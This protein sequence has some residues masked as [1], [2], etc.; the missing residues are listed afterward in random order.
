MAMLFF[1]A[2]FGIA[3]S[4]TAQPG[5][6]PEKFWVGVGGGVQPVSNSFSDDF[7]KPLYTEDEQVS[8][9]YPVKSGVLVAGS[10]G[11][12][13]WKQLALGVGFTYYTASGDADVDAELPHPF[14]D[15]QFRHVS[16]TTDASRSE[17]GVHIMAAWMLPLS[18]RFRIILS[19][20]P[21]VLNVSQTVVTDVQFSETFPYDTAEF[22]GATKT[23]ASHTA[24]GF[25]A[26]RTCSGCSPAASGPAG[27]CSIRTRERSSRPPIER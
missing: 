5:Q 11:Y 3:P 26:G 19:A 17:T 10:G 16:G 9:S 15:N 23:D 20:G 4:A 25:N 18:N 27:S 6:W 13:I 12:R 8:V 7:T 1:A 2:L 22:T 21:S 14:F 24:I